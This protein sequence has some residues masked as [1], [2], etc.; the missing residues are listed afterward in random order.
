MLRKKS[1]F[2]SSPSEQAH[3]S[4]P[5]KSRT[6][7]DNPHFAQRALSSLHNALRPRPGS[8]NSHS[9]DT[10]SN[11]MLFGANRSQSDLSIK[12]LH[13]NHYSSSPTSN[14]NELSHHRPQYTQSRH[15]SNEGKAKFTFSTYSTTS[16]GTTDSFYSSNSAMSPL[17][18][19]DNSSTTSR[20]RTRIPSQTGSLPSSPLGAYVNGHVSTLSLQEPEN[21]LGSGF[22]IK[23]NA[24]PPPM[25]ELRVRHLQRGTTYA[26]YLTKFSSR[27]FFS[28]KQWKRRYFILHEKSLHCFKSSDPQHPL[29]ESITL[30]ADTI[31]CVTDIFSGKRYCLQITCPGEKNWYVLADSASEMSGWLKELKGTVLQFRTMHLTR[32]GTHYSDSSEMSDLSASSLTMDV[33]SVPVIPSQYDYQL[34]YTSNPSS[35]PPPRPV[36]PSILASSQAMLYQ[37]PHVSLNPPPRSMTP[38]LLSS[39]PTP[40]QERRRKNST[41]ST[42][43]TDYAS[44][45]TVMERAEAMTPVDDENLPFPFEAPVVVP[46]QRKG[47]SSTASS[48]RVSIVIDRPETMITLPRRSSQRLMGSPSRPMSPVSSRP[49]SPNRPSPRSSLVVSPPPRSI[50]RPASVSV[51]HSTQIPSPMEIAAM[52]LASTATT[53][54]E[55]SLARITSI[56]HTRDISTL[57]RYNGATVLTGLRHSS[58]RSNI[59]SSFPT[60]PPTALPPAPSSPSLATSER[61]LSPLPDLTTAPTLPLPEPPKSPISPAT[62]AALSHSLSSGSTRRISIIPRHHDPEVMLACRS[63][64]ARSRTQSQESALATA[65]SGN[66]TP[67]P[68]LGAVATNTQDEG[69]DPAAMK[70]E[71]ASMIRSLVSSPV[72]KSFVLPAPPTCSQ[73]EPPIGSGHQRNH[74]RQ[75]SS[76]SHKHS[77]SSSS[78]CSISSFGSTSSNNQSAPPSPSSPH[79]MF[80][81]GI[82]APM[83][84]KKASNRDSNHCTRLSLLTLPPGSVPMPPQTALPPIPVSISV[85]T[86]PTVAVENIYIEALEVDHVDEDRVTDVKEEVQEEKESHR[87]SEVQGEIDQASEVE[88]KVLSSEEQVAMGFEM[89][90]EEEEETESET[91]DQSGSKDTVE[92]SEDEYK[93][94]IIDD[95][96]E[97]LSISE[98]DDSSTAVD[99]SETGKERSQDVSENEEEHKKEPTMIALAKLPQ[100]V[101][102]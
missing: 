36:H 75:S 23:A 60:A 80:T 35:S 84:P 82:H 43:S 58:S 92:S 72:Q 7:E 98:S 13:I 51:R 27:T 3:T 39:T 91:D 9:S 48:H 102:V 63:K 61:P 6:K 50:H 5:S 79:A 77:L 24:L 15:P 87:V 47:S 74:H 101:A 38:K 68:R 94:L 12:Q 22:D 95:A 97:R 71:R 57:A 49:M 93:N 32:P 54:T 88:A 26:G 96:V 31:V 30:C 52:G 81:Q 1:S 73:P 8:R 90:L 18:D 100:E 14:N 42:Q 40:G 29:L 20:Q 28:R 10:S 66:S 46:R 33:P 17:T 53:I 62:R 83:S 55:G 70:A 34:S 16:N 19:D 59:L 44:F 56:R 65:R 21:K 45:G 76:S 85:T 64:T 89:I 11:N 69:H 86:S 25:P 2:T 4:P 78:F 99:S 67:S 41:V 37:G